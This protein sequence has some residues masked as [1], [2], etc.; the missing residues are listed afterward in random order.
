MYDYLN[1]SNNRSLDEKQATVEEK[2]R[3]TAAIQSAIASVSKST[4]HVLVSAGKDACVATIEAI[5]ESQ[6]TQLKSETRIISNLRYR[7][8]RL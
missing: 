6:T 1:P 4:R 3:Q 5:E 7:L 8:S 2:V